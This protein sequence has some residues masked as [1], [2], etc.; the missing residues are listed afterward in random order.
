MVH[1]VYQPN[2]L[3]VCKIQ[4]NVPAAIGTRQEREEVNISEGI[5][6]A[7]QQD[8]LREDLNIHTRPAVINIDTGAQ[9]NVLEPDEEMVDIIPPI[10]VGTASTSP[11][12]DDV[13]TSA[14]QG[15]S[16]NDDHPRHSQLGSHPIEGMSSIQPVDCHITSGIR[17]MVIED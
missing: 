13:V 5:A 16:T 4:L 15:S 2:Q 8:V 3:T 6:I 11:H 17:Q 12:I 1:L 14:P 9:I 10:A 7:P